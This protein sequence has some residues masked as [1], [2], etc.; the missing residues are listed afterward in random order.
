MSAKSNFEECFQG[1]QKPGTRSAL[2][3]CIAAVVSMFMVCFNKF[4]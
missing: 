4:I 2:H 3:M 1:R